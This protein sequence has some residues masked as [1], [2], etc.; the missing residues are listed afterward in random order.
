MDRPN[1]WSVSSE[2]LKPHDQ[3]NLSALAGNWN[4]NLQ[5]IVTLP[6]TVNQGPSVR[7]LTPQAKYSANPP[8]F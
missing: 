4:D 8:R 1:S 6:T 7:Y 2:S 3:Y 5:V